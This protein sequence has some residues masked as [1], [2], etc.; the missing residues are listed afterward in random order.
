MKSKIT[1]L[2]AIRDFTGAES[3]LREF[4]LLDCPEEDLVAYTALLD[5]IRP[6]AEADK[7]HPFWAWITR[8]V[9]KA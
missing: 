9:V 4:L 6:R 2:I 8:K 3:A 7:P 1:R 5:H